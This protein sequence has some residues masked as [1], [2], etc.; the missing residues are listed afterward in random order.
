MLVRLFFCNQTYDNKLIHNTKKSQHKPPTS[1]IYLAITQ[2]MV[3]KILEIINF[4]SSLWQNMPTEFLIFLMAL[5]PLT[6][7]RLAIPVGIALGCSPQN[8]FLYAVLGNVAPLL[9][10]SWL[11]PKVFTKL[12]KSRLLAGFWAKTLRKSKNLQLK[13]CLG[14]LLFVG[15]P[16]PG[17][18]V[19]SACIIAEIL[20]LPKIPA[21]LGILGGI[22]IS[23]LIITLSTLGVVNIYHFF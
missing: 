21:I 17:T 3:A 15:I 9:L 11:L 5:L 19:W 13:G 18:G 22:T 12:K 20:Q 6:E 10:L 8:A 23:A 14:L 2:R 4:I 1:S 16:L 7:L